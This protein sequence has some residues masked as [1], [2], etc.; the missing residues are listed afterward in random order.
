MTRARLSTTVNGRLLAQARAL[1]TGVTDA[2]LVDKALSALLSRCRS[3]DVDGCYAAYDEHPL[4]ESDEW[5]DLDTFRQAAA[6]F[7][8][9][10]P[11]PFTA[12]TL[13]LVEREARLLQNALAFE[14]TSNI[15][16]RLPPDADPVDV[17]R[18]GRDA[19]FD[20]DYT[21]NP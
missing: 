19:G 4:G 18:E 7:V 5:G 14:R 3:D 11:D 20:V 12:S 17:I 1:H 8:R 9:S 13:S 2:D 16:V 6:A 21:D 10:Q 15:R